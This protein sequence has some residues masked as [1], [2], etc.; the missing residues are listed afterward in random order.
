MNRIRHQRHALED[1]AG[2]TPSAIRFKRKATRKRKMK[3][4]KHNG[5]AR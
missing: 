5:W 4:R 2:S 1:I 3:Q